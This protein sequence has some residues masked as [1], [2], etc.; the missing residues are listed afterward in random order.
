LEIPWLLESY[1][2]INTDKMARKLRDSGEKVFLDSGA[3]SAWTKGA[4]INLDRF[5]DF[6]LKH[7]DLFSVVS[8]LDVI[9]SAEGTWHNQQAMEKRGVPA[10]PVYHYGEDPRWCEHY[11]KNYE[12]MALGGFGVANRKQMAQW[13][14]RVWERYLI[15]GSGNARLKVHGFA[16]TAVPLMER[17]PWFSVDSS[18]WVQ[19]ARVGAIYHPDW[20]PIQI[21]STNPM[22]KYEGHHYDNLPPDYRAV[23]KKSIEDTGYTVE[24]LAT[25]YELRHAY[26]MWSYCEKGRRINERSAAPTHFQEEL[27]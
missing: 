27:F 2:Y 21:S 6:A 9:G 14:D 16:I 11:V 23:I 1:H 22:R 5:C 4:T 17:Y 7:E 12:Y 8:V 15:D 24:G 13:L 19:V 10:I 18:S 20:G 3:Y 26:C 25:R